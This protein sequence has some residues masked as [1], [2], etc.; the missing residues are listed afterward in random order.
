MYGKVPHNPS[1]SVS[2]NMLPYS[3]NPTD[4]YSLKT[5]VVCRSLNTMPATT[6]S[7]AGE[8]CHPLQGIPFKL[9]PALEMAQGLQ[10]DPVL[11]DVKRTLERVQHLLTSKDFD[12]D[13]TLE[14][15]FLREIGTK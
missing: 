7:A 2:S 14:R 15:N 1:S 10:Q 6:Q 3:I 12:Y 11:E 9:A 4:I 5:Q 8:T 13:C